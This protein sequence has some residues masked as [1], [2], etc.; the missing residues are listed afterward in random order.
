MSTPSR[1]PVYLSL[2]YSGSVLSWQRQG[3]SPHLYHYV[4]HKVYQLVFHYVYQY[5][6]HCVAARVPLG[7]AAR[8][9][10]C[11]PAHV[12]LCVPARA[13][14]CIPAR[15][16]LCVPAREPLCV[17][18]TCTTLPWNNDSKHSACVCSLLTACHLSP[19]V[20][21][22]MNVTVQVSLNWKK[23]P[24]LDQ[25]FRLSILGWMPFLNPGEG[26]L[27]ARQSYP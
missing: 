25:T 27:W 21:F 1:F 22:C 24:Q 9:P 19:T 18:A 13:P 11:I 2:F 16:P 14:V 3:T 12:P 4:Y 5:V 15:V 26:I 23:L 8:A 7:V 17:L 6:N 10:V 20:L